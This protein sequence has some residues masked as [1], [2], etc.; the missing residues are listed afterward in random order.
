MKWG[1]CFLFCLLFLFIFCS[2]KYSQM[3]F[4]SSILLHSIS[5][6]NLC[7]FLSFF[8]VIA[9]SVKFVEDLVQK[10]LWTNHNAWQSSIQEA[11]S[12]LLLDSG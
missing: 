10:K 4:A 12:M 8:L 6:H 9:T 3:D 1:G 2:G 11:S 5:A 7:F